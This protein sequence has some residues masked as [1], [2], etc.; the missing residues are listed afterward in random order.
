MFGLG[1]WLCV[2]ADRNLRG[3]NL[4]QALSPLLSSFMLYHTVKNT[5]H[6][7]VTFLSKIK[8]MTTQWPVGPRLAFKCKTKNKIG[9]KKKKNIS[10]YTEPD[11]MSIV[12]RG[13]QLTRYSQR[14]TLG[15][16]VWG[17]QSVWL[18]YIWEKVHHYFPSKVGQVY[19]ISGLYN[20]VF[21]FVL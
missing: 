5:P 4:S 21:Y 6:T 19:K 18:R 12:N 13:G 9:Q 16:S 2:F 10:I 17:I 20:S 11:T 7:D 14:L 8:F 1:Y 15:R 3:K